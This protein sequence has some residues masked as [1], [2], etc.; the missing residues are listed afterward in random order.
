MVSG[1]VGG[2]THRKLD[3]EEFRGFSLSDNF[4]PLVFVN[5]VDTKGAQIFTLAHELAHIWLGQSAVDRPEFG[6]DAEDLSERWCNAVAAEFVVPGSALPPVVDESNLASEVATL[7]D[8]FRVS[9]LV[10]A[11]RLF[12]QNLLSWDA[13]RTYYVPEAER[14]RAVVAATRASGGGNYYNTQPYRVSRRFARALI[15]D[16][17]EGQ[18]L[19]RDAYRLLGVRSAG[20]LEE[21]GHRVGV[22]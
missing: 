16:T 22:A 9:T 20:T 11:K 17:F 15:S 5:A 10:I 4:A 18:T 1:I 3:T 8:Y 2:N 19:H 21:L 14:L 6:S 13:F 7:A 12:D